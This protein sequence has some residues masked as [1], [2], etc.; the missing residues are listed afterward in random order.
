MRYLSSF[1]ASGLAFVLLVSNASAQTYVSVG[2]EGRAAAALRVWEPAG[3]QPVVDH[4]LVLVPLRARHS[5][6]VEL[7]VRYDCA[8]SER[9]E[10]F[11][12]VFSS[13]SDPRKSSQDPTNIT[14][15]LADAPELAPQFAYV[16]GSAARDRRASWEGLDSFVRAARR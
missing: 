13:N 9:T 1:L 4:S 12:T 6:Y 10:R 15:R 11:R 7:G 14:V 8:R 3:G 2:N 16:C 5:E